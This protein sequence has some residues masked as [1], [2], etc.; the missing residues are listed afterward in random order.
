MVLL[1]CPLGFILHFFVLGADN[2]YEY[3]NADYI[4]LFTREW[5]CITKE[6]IPDIVGHYKYSTSIWPMSRGN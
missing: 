1:H 3:Y 4:L 6:H 2:I 5:N